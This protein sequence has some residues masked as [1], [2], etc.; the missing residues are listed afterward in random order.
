[1]GHERVPCN[2][3]GGNR[4]YVK[5]VWRV[6]VNCGWVAIAEKREGGRMSDERE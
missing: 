4:G 1:M 2:R 3:E 6:S 5:G